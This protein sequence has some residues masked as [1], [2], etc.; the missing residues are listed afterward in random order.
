ML[1][2]VQVFKTA[3]VL[4]PS[5]VLDYTVLTGIKS[6]SHAVFNRLDLELGVMVAA[7]LPFKCFQTGAPPPHE[8]VLVRSILYSIDIVILNYVVL[9]SL[10]GIAET[11]VND[12]ARRYVGSPPMRYRTNKASNTKRSQ[13]YFYIVGR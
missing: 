10:Q 3:F 6:I 1:R 4:E 11:A 7:F 9:Y 2:L 8:I 12:F 13:S 5:N